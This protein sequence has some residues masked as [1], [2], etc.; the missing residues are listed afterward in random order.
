MTS[1]VLQ[2]CL[3]TIPLARSL[4]DNRISIRSAKAE[5][6]DNLLSLTASG[7]RVSRESGRIEGRTRYNMLIVAQRRIPLNSDGIT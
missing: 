1:Q 7:S 2:P 3:D 4:P 5:L 6:L